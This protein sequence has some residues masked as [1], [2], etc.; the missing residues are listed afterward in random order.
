MNTPNDTHDPVERE[1][2]AATEYTGRDTALW[3]EA[4]EARRDRSRASR[5]RWLLSRPP[6]WASAAALVLFAMIVV[7]V[8]LPRLNSAARPAS[9]PE[10]LRRQAVAPSEAWAEKEGRALF[11]TRT[12][13]SGYESAGDF[14]DGTSGVTTDRDGD[15]VLGFDFLTR[16]GNPESKSPSSPPLTTATDR[17]VIRKVAIDLQPVDVRASFQKAA[18]LINDGLGEYIE[19]SLITGEGETLHATMTLRVET[20]RLSE[21]RQQ[22]RNLGKVLSENA[23]GEDVTDRILDIEARLRNER[24]VEQELLELFDKR[25]DAPL[26]EILDLRAQI[27]TVR[28]QIEQLDAQRQRAGKL[29]ALATVLVNLS[30]VPVEKKV[31]E[32]K[33]SMGEDVLKG[34]DNA[35]ENGL[36]S[37]GRSIAWL[38]EAA[39]GGLIAW[40]FL[41]ALLTIAVVLVRKVLRSA[42]KEPAPA[43]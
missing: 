31:E 18:L 4:L 2:I 39:I 25:K 23:T 14:S 11:G 7:A 13:M 37:L 43:A 6:T 28:E 30:A 34:L 21:I 29:V 36:R 8:A 22:L 20:G 41:G 40:I 33:S 38:I 10:A 35:W 9:G 3:R 16:R 15:T 24:R 32:K 12:L 27:G 5:W 26:K 42:W 17:Q 19:N 1:L